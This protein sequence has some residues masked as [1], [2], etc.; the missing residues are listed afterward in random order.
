MNWIFI[1]VNSFVLAQVMHM[2]F[3]EGVEIIT[4]I[5]SSLSL[6][7]VKEVHDLADLDIFEV[8]MFN[9]LLLRAGDIVL[10]CLQSSYC[11]NIDCY[12]VDHSDRHQQDH[13]C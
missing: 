8:D 7:L 10:I 4:G 5:L 12:V 9:D 11:H 3:D 1:K 13:R 2:T 6:I